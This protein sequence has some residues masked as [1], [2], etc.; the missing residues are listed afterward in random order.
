MANFYS[1]LTWAAIYNHSIITGI[2]LSPKRSHPRKN[3]CFD[4]DFSVA[5]DTQ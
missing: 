4:F 5:A 2:L 1:Q 3:K